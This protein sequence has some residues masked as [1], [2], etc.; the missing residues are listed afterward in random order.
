MLTIATRPPGEQCQSGKKVAGDEIK[1]C[2]TQLDL[3]GITGTT[4]QA[5][6]VSRLTW[7]NLQAS[8]GEAFGRIEHLSGLFIKGFAGG[9]AITT[10]NLQDEDFGLPP[11]MVGPITTTYS[12]TNSDQRDGRL[13]YATIDGGWTW[14]TETSKL[15][16][17]IGYNYFHQLMNAYG[18]TQTALYYPVC[19][20]PIPTSVSVITEQYDWNAVRLGFNGRWRFWDGFAFDLDFAW[21]PHAWLD[22]SDT[23]WLRSFSAPEQGWSGFSNVQIDAL[24]SYQFVNGIS[25]GV[26]GR[27]WN[28]DTAFGQALFNES[29]LGGFPQTIAVHSQRW[30]VFIQASYKFGGELPPTRFAPCVWC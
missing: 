12:S 24:L 2:V 20:A 16:I 29:S 9:G 5:A 8:S 4:S 26:G 28:I 1:E 3:Y 13:A 27:F 30:G 7:T 25:L 10:G 6:S 15:G 14:R 21:L 23:H 22:A 17:F 11:F 19:G 18:C